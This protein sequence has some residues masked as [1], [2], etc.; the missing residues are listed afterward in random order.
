MTS[1]RNNGAP[2]TGA[3]DHTPL[4]LQYIYILDG[5][6]RMLVYARLLWVKVFQHGLSVMYDAEQ[7]WG[8][9]G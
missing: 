5:P 8:S 6:V 7:S 4:F 9:G 2:T 1:N 3:P